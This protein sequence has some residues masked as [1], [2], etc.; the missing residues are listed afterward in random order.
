MDPVT[1]RRSHPAA[2]ERH[3][4]EDVP[5][6]ASTGA[7]N[8]SS[9]SSSE[10]RTPYVDAEKDS[11]TCHA[12]VCW[13]EVFFDPQKGWMKFWNPAV[14]WRGLTCR[15]RES[16]FYAFDAF[17]ALAFFWVSNTHLSEGLSELYL[18]Y[19]SWEAQGDKSYTIAAAQGVTVFFVISGF[20]NIYVALRINERFGVS[21]YGITNCLL[22][23]FDKHFHRH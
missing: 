8:S 15:E 3:S 11:R 19:S 13:R 22:L 5:L 20:L 12:P 2:D 4:H 18:D 17:R 1:L 7:D 21:R 10:R 23:E 6:L 9:S 16:S 14:T